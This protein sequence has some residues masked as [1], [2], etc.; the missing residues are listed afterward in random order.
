M[1]TNLIDLS[2]AIAG[3]A[4]APPLGYKA[5]LTC[6]YISPTEIQVLP[7]EATLEDDAGNRK[8]AKISSPQAVSLP[9]LSGG[10]TVFVFL[11]GD[12]TLLIDTV[13]PSGFS[14]LI[15]PFRLNGN[16]SFIDFEQ[17]E[18]WIYY[19]T[20]MQELHQDNIADGSY[21]FTSAFIPI[22]PAKE[23][24]ISGNA[25]NYNTNDN[26]MGF[27]VWDKVPG[28]SNWLGKGLSYAIAQ[29]ITRSAGDINYGLWSVSTPPNNNLRIYTLG[30]KI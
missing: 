30:Y 27:A 26:F 24:L 1:G 19:Y 9:S 28:V 13:K 20:D 16:G 5:G 11:T 3:S 7:G 14:A 6:V 18:N 21:S 25:A 22:R 8:I 17:S 10:E 29:A 2:G 4:I 15:A 12:N 23:V